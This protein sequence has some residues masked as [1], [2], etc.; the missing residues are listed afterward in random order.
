MPTPTPPEQDLLI[1]TASSRPHKPL[2]KQLFSVA[3]VIAILISVILAFSGEIML[4]IVIVSI[5]FAYYTWSVYIPD[6]TTYRITTWGI[7]AHGQ[8]YRWEQLN[9]WWTEGNLLLIDA[10]LE[11]FRRIYLVLD[12]KTTPTQL[13]DLLSD[14]LPFDQPTPTSLDKLAGWLTRTFP[15]TK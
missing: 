10:P 9:R 8:F 15:L 2:D 7:R 6:S 14:Y 4:I 11:R 13:Q 3:V 1:W 12:P 5:L